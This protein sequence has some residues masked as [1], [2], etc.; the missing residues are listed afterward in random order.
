MKSDVVWKLLKESYDFQEL[1]PSAVSVAFRNV[2]KAN[3]DYI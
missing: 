1:W 3:L 2:F